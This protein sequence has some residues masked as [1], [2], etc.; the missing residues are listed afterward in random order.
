[1]RKVLE[2]A[3]AIG[4]NIE[5]YGVKKDQVIEISEPVGCDKCHQGYKGRIGVFEAI[6]TD[7][8]L[9][10]IMPNN[11]SERE[12]KKIGNMQ[13][14]LNMKEDGVI[15]VMNG[16]TSLAELESVVDLEEE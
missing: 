6:Y 4:K 14:T 11:P 9:E 3:V 12:I 10:K 8:N 13:H 15:K 2:E 1:M 16:V 7:E 5:E